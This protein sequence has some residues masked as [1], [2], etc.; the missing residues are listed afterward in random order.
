MGVHSARGGSST[1]PY[2]LTVSLEVDGA[3]DP[4]EPNDSPYAAYALHSG[5]IGISSASI[6]AMNDQ[7]WFQWIVQ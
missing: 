6:H 1:S 4:A 5:S 2:T 3:F 7:D